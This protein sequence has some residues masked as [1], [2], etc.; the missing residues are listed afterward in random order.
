[1]INPIKTQGSIFCDLLGAKLSGGIHQTPS[2]SLYD[3]RGR[4]L[5]L[6]VDS[7]SNRIVD[8]S[9]LKTEFSFNKITHSFDRDIPLPTDRFKTDSFG[10]LFG[11]G[12]V[13]PR[14]DINKHWND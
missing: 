14:R 10:N 8:G 2:G 5:G 12:C 6:K 3:D 4:D 7:F 9:G 1:M 13:N 11:A